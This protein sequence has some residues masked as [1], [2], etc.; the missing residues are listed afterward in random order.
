MKFLL[1][2]LLTLIISS[3]SRIRPVQLVKDEKGTISFCVVGDI[4]DGSSTQIK[5]AE[6][7]KA[8]GCQKLILLGDL[9][10]PKGIKSSED[11][12]LREYFF[13]PYGSFGQIYLVLGNHDYEG[14]VEA[15]VKLSSQDKRI[16]H[17]AS[18]F[19]ERIGD[20]CLFFLDTNFHASV[21]LFEQ[22]SKWISHST[23]GC[24]YMAA[25]SHHP[26][27]SSGKRHG[28]ATNKVK[29]FFEEYVI[30]KF[31]ILFSGHE[32]I[33]NDEGNVQGTRQIIS[34]AGGKYDQENL[35]GF[36]ILKLNIE[37][38][39]LSEVTLIPLGVD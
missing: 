21:D 15:W 9:I 25:F 1:L 10:Y 14:N 12:I 27:V 37:H 30:G 38:P 36:A 6:A 2:L 20:T 8:S 29:E 3:C 24:K 7:M 4:G 22:E 39:A 32:H 13:K 31:A 11:T 34:G 19:R 28:P 23:E 16:T 18:Y 26:Y 35:P 33:L 5:V 17:P